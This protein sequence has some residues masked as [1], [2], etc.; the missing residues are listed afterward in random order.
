MR[1]NPNENDIKKTKEYLSSSILP[2]DNELINPEIDLLFN[3][4]QF[5]KTI[6]NCVILDSCDTPLPP[7]FILKKINGNIVF[8]KFNIDNL[9]KTTSKPN[10]FELSYKSKIK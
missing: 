4:K 1:N 10:K 8:V 9:P 6:E 7:N 2:N 3:K 5:N